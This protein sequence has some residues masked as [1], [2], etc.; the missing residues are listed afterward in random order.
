M[1]ELDLKANSAQGIWHNNPT[2][3]HLLGLSPLLAISDRASKAIALGV[4]M[5]LVCLLSAT[6]VRLLRHK[7]DMPWRFIWYGLI[8][9]A[10]TS[11]CTL[12]LQLAF[13]PLWRELGIYS[14]LIASNFALL[15]KMDSFRAAETLGNSVTAAL[16]LSA[17]LLLAL[18]LFATIREFLLTGTLL[19]DWYLLLLQDSSL[20]SSTLAHEEVFRFS[21]LQPAG[22]IL[23]GLLIALA[24]WTG[25]LKSD[26]LQNRTTETVKRARITGRLEK[27]S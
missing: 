20:A 18:V 21:K 5:L 12:F 8:M 3:A 9:A 7:I 25:I 13:F 15:I 10:Y 27:E 2:L 24:N 26:P 22:F 23:L 16:R 6:T 17:G 4:C 11:L 19:S 14:L 1:S